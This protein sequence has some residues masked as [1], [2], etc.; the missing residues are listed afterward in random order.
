[1]R[2]FHSH[3]KDALVHTPRGG[4]NP[5]SDVATIADSAR[6]TPSTV[7]IPVEPTRFAANAD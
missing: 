7:L 2:E 5:H 4:R 6:S 3:V 1:M